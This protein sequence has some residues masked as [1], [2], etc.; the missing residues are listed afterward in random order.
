VRDQP[1]KRCAIYTRKSTE[2]GLDQAFNSLDAQ[3]EACAAY[4]MSQQHEGWI[5]A[6]GRY[7]DGGHSGG[8]LARPGLVQ[9]LADVKVGSIDVIIVYKIDRLTRSLTD[10]AKI[11]D[12]LD[13]AGASFVSITQ[14]FNT[15]T[16][17]G[18]L[19]LNVLL[20]FAQFER[21]VIAERVRDKVA[22]SKARGI[23]MGGPLPL[24]YEVHERSLV[25]DG[26]QAE[27]VRYIFRRYLE[28]GS[29]ALLR[30][31]LDQQGITT[32][33]RTRRDGSMYGGN[34]W[35]PGPLYALLKNRIYI[36]KI[37]HKD[38]CYDGLH[39]PIID[40]E[41]FAAVQAQLA[42]NAANKT[43]RAY[44][45]HCLLLTGMIRDG[46][47]RPLTPR[48]A[49]KGMKRYGYYVSNNAL[50]EQGSQE[51]PIWR[52]PALQIE[53]A[54]ML[55][56]TEV[57]EQTEGWTEHDQLTSAQCGEFRR[58]ASTLLTS[59]RDGKRYEQC[60]LLKSLGLEIAVS[61]DRIDAS[62]CAQALSHKLELD[63]LNKTGRISLELSPMIKQR[64]QELRMIFLPHKAGRPAIDEKLTQLIIDAH[65]ARDKLASGACASDH[66][67][68]RRK[69]RLTWLAP[70]IIVSIM[71]GR[72]PA[73]LT[74]R[75]LLR[76]AAL[77]LSWQEQ[78]TVLGFTR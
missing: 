32:K 46:L 9:L 43:K 22:A 74:A 42:S 59:L 44:A 41:L 6:G 67:K 2:E 30:A 18:R 54:I 60:A 29:V 27:Q 20:S 65:R 15:T 52:I 14:S 49:N 12:V 28:L 5:L 63:Y 45:K 8:N 37:V 17:I 70:D 19:T 76:S 13:G 35:W 31:D 68:L 21:E 33:V 64:G 66:A 75:S 51:L 50:N 56:L 10:F 58:A 3:H 72:G 53:A 55:Q 23:W 39:P 4:I 34:S 71:E 48:H 69:A 7:D 78:R 73:E 24:G 47:E 1:I 40:K 57:I 11:V 38:K 62:I 61:Q 25:I 16:S 77:P 36:G 26:G